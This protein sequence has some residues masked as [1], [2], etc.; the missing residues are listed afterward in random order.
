MKRVNVGYIDC[1]IINENSLHVQRTSKWPK[2]DNIRLSVKRES[3]YFEENQE[4]MSHI[5]YVDELVKE[6]LLFRGFS[7]T[8]KAFDNDLKAEKEKGFRVSVQEITIDRE[9]QNIRK[10]CL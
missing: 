6:Y 9:R 8:L 7:Q 5:Q 1:Q 3:R 10:Q 2:D 4:K